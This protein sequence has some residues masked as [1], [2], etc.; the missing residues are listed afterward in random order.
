[1][2]THK[3]ISIC[4]CTLALTLSVLLFGMHFGFDY[5]K[6]ETSETTYLSLSPEGQLATYYA[7]IVLGLV[8]HLLASFVNK[9]PA[10]FVS[11]LSLIYVFFT[12]LGLYHE[13]LFSFANA[14]LA[15]AMNRIVIPIDV[16]NGC[17][18]FIL[19]GSLIF[20]VVQK[21]KQK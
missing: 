12:F 9:A 2:K 6:R 14:G 3:I 20:A 15:T 5:G 17:L 13:R 19:A 16:V 8:T 11:A 10:Y 18:L 21:I 7:R 1:M 4:V